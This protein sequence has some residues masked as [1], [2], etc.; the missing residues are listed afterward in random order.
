MQLCR[1]WAIWT[2]NKFEYSHIRVLNCIVVLSRFWIIA[3]SDTHPLNEIEMLAR[4]YL[5][6]LWESLEFMLNNM[7][8]CR[9]SLNYLFEEWFMFFNQP[10]ITLI[11]QY[12]PIAKSK[13]VNFIGI[14]LIDTYSKQNNVYLWNKDN[15]IILVLSHTPV[16][17]SSDLLI[18]LKIFN[19]LYQE[20]L[21]TLNTI[22]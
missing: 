7:L 16:V 2:L 8:V 15:C 9:F 5:N 22:Q 4:L 11:F 12:V 20:I 6:T 18:P 3:F 14:F 10:T 1:V 19:R 13:I 17:I 21:I